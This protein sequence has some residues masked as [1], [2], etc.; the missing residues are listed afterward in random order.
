MATRGEAMK[1]LR[2]INGMKEGDDGAFTYVLGFDDGR[3][4]LVFLKVVD[5]FIV[6]TSPFAEK[7]DISA[8][9]AIDLARVFGVVDIGTLYCLR[10]VLFI[11]DLDESEVVNGIRWLGGQ[12]DILESEV[13]GDA[14]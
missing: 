7:D 11:E 1:Y 13:G 5:D 14:L 12:A 4:Q 10:H 8:M 3:S 2:G 6:L 9:K